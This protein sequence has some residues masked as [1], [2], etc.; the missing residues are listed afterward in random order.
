MR[1]YDA[2][3]RIFFRYIVNN[4]LI[5]VLPMLMA[6]LAARISFQA[7]LKNLDA[8]AA[9]SLEAGVAEID[10][11]LAELPKMS[12]QI[13]SDYEIGYYLKTATPLSG[14]EFYNL[15]RVQAKLSS[16]VLGNGILG[17]CLLYMSKSGLIV[18][19]DGFAAYDGFYGTLFACD[20][21]TA[22]QWRDRI[23]MAPDGEGFLPTLSVRIGGTG[24]PAVDGAVYRRPIG[25]GD[26]FLGTVVGILDNGVMVR[27]LSQLPDRYGGRVEVRDA[28]G[29]AVCA[30]G[31]KGAS[32]AGDGTEG[33]LRRYQVRSPLSG[34]T[35]TA[36]LSET[37]VLAK[38]RKVRDIAFL[39]L[40]LG[41]AAGVGASYLFAVTSSKPLR[42]LFRLVLRGDEEP[43]GS[44]GGVYERVERAIVRMADSNLRLESEA[45]SAQ[46]MTKAYFFQNLLRGSYPDREGFEEDR[47]AFRV[48]FRASPYYTVV[49]R[50]A[51]LHAAAEGESHA[52]LRDAL[53]EAAARRMGEGEHA[54]PVSFDDL[55]LVK[56][57]EDGRPFR[58][59]AAA[60]VDGLRADLAPGIRGGFLFGIGTPTP[61]PFLLMVSH[62]EALTAAASA[63]DDREAV[64][65]YADAPQGKASYFYPL[66][67]EENLMK[68]VRSANPD[69]LETLLATVREENF[70]A[71]RLS[72]PETRNLFVELQGTVLRLIDGL[73]VDGAAIRGDLAR[74]GGRPP[75][76][77]GLDGLS[78]I[79]RGL[80]RAYDL[81]KKSHNAALLASLQ[82]YI[83]EH[84]VEADLGLTR[85][86]DALG[87][88]ENYLSNFHKEQTGE[89]LSAAVQRIR[90]DEAAR[91]LRSTDQGVDA[92]AR[93]CG[94]DNTTSFRRAFK[95][96]H[97]LSPSEYRM[98]AA[99]AAPR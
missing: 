89:C 33:P 38:A 26:Y 97:G 4:V 55:A 39:L 42:R 25:H 59:Q 43:G 40:G 68:A 16:F 48:A 86:A 9:S 36:F 52:L 74:W 83:A 23:L 3:E 75:S 79:L 27:M 98:R 78:E 15:K 19:E 44:P 49:C 81:G 85:I 8:T 37:K 47:R 41:L 69:L 51:P 21:Y 53:L 64:R 5:L 65:F 66:A 32:A 88:S 7:I 82:A 54:I 60:F 34:W 96:L 30:T 87:I 70:S 31:P 2:G 17:H 20:G 61:D 28:D 24:G 77:E 84:Y 71:R 13:A 57:V 90:F 50:L 99:R 80:M 93:R 45:L 63:A 22:D 92:V 58:E 35:F 94:Y 95:R 72:T 62:A 76:P 10:R 11:M 56:G 1:R 18:Y 29:N 6:A 91:L 73:P 12:I 67:V 46:R 14:I